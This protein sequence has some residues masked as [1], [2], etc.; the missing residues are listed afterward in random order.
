M[1][2]SAKEWLKFVAQHAK[3]SSTLWELADWYEKNGHVSMPVEVFVEI[4]T[5]HNPEVRRL[6]PPR[7]TGPTHWSRDVDPGDMPPAKMKERGLKG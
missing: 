4:Y 5:R 2:L 7:P 3:M 1:N 6:E